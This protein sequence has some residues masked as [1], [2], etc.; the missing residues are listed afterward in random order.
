MTYLVLEVPARTSLLKL[1][2]YLY[3]KG[4]TAK[5]HKNSTPDHTMT[6]DRSVR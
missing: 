6:F 5:Y 4:L 1:Y 2:K 3:L